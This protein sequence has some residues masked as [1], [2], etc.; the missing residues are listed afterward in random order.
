MRRGKRVLTASLQ[1]L[2]RFPIRTAA[3]HTFELSSARPSPH[4]AGHVLLPLQ[5]IPIGWSLVP[6]W[7]SSKLL[8]QH[9]CGCRRRLHTKED[10]G[11]STAAIVFRSWVCQNARKSLILWWPRE[12]IE[13]PTRGFSAR[14]PRRA[15]SLNI[16]C[17]LPHVSWNIWTTYRSDKYV[18]RMHTARN[19]STS[20]A[21][22]VTSVTVRFGPHGRSSSLYP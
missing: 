14:G 2:Y 1:P 22:L 19:Y 6:F 16:K 5:R 13:P 18:F 10:L 21:H 3:C 12:G 17:L 11:Y 15:M 4:G 7:T 8:L 9:S 20:F